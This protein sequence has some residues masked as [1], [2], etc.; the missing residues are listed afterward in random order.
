MIRWICDNYNDKSNSL[1]CLFNKM[2]E[3][4]EWYNISIYILNQ[5]LFC[6]LIQN[7]QTTAY[8][9]RNRIWMMVILIV[10]KFKCIKLASNIS[11]FSFPSS[12]SFLLQP[13]DL[14]ISCTFKSNLI[15]S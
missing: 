13:N 1:S 9:I 11:P 5:F 15:N 14:L 4:N 12:N 6:L 3:N 8:K 10:N 2:D 7:T